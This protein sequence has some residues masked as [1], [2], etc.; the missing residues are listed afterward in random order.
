MSSTLNKK[1]SF[2][3]ILPELRVLSLVNVMIETVH[4]EHLD[5]RERKCPLSEPF[6]LQNLVRQ[7]LSCPRLERLLVLENNPTI[8]PEDDISEA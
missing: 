1:P 5:E 6:E 7:P 3:V 4:K 2:Q 8:P